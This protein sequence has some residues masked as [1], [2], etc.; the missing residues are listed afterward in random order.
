MKQKIS[1][2]GVIFTGSSRRKSR[3]PKTI[4]EIHKKKRRRTGKEKGQRRLSQ[5]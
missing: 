5:S 4:S 2:V 1:C 3:T